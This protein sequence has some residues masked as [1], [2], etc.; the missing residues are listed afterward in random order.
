MAF[1]VPPTFADGDILTAA[2]LNILSDDLEYLYSLVAGANV[3]F[4]QHKWDGSPTEEPSRTYIFHR[5]NRYLHYK[6]RL[7]GGETAD[8]KI[9]VNGNQEYLDSTNRTSGYEWVG[10][11][12]LTGIT[13]VPAVG[14]SYE[15]YANIEWATGGEA[16]LDY[17]LESDETAL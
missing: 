13:A 3:P 14:D 15:V 2:Q 4:L 12:D 6:I 10:Y 7:T 1:I 9:F 17:L 8:F 11:I 16:K 5:A